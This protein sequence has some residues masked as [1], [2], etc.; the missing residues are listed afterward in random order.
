MNARRRRLVDGPADLGLLSGYTPAEIEL[1][2]QMCLRDHLYFTRFFFKVRESNPFRVGLHHPV[3][4]SAIDRVLRGEITRLIVNI[5][6]GYTKT[7]EVVIALG[8]RAYAINPRA[9]ILHTSAGDQ[10]VQ[11]NSTDIRDIV[12]TVEFQTLFPGVT[13]RQ[14]SKSKGLWRTNAGGQFR[15]APAAGMITGFRAGTMDDPRPE[16][17]FPNFTGLFLIDDPIKPED[18]D[19]E[20]KRVQINERID[21]TFA[22]RLA[23]E[24]VP[25]IVVMQ[26]IHDEDMSGYLLKGRFRGT[27]WHHLFLPVEVPERDE[28][29]NLPYPK[30]FQ[31]GIQIDHDLPPGPLWADKHNATQIEELKRSPSVYAAQYAQVPRSFETSIFKPD[32][33]RAYEL[34]PTMSTVF[35]LVDPSK[36]KRKSQAQRARL[37]DRT[38]I[39]VLMM[40]VNRNLYLVDGYCHRMQLT[41]RWKHLA[42]LYRRY[43]AMPGVQMI[44]FGYEQYGLQ[45]DIEHFNTQMEEHGPR[46]HIEELNYPR[47][48]GHAKE[49]RIERL[50][51]PMVGNRL[52]FPS[53]IYD[54][55]DRRDKFWEGTETGIDLWDA[56]GNTALQERAIK[57]NQ[58]WR[59]A[60]PIKRVDERGQ[61]YDLTKTIMEE[62][63]LFPDAPYDDASDCLSRIVDMQP[64][65]P[66]PSFVNGE[67]SLESDEFFDK[68]ED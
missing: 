37:S 38:A 48:G 15:A 51:A 54:P 49:T 29:G 47:D 65:P 62:L 60:R 67:D 57:N 46:F 2:R 25:I 50:E 43:K 23:T 45:S 28:N 8:A 39:V 22:S 16:S 5:P 3:I 27:R 4:A 18:K 20:T 13:F 34:K 12:N 36:G 68:Y 32:M 21:N 33:F 63:E 6:P 55:N 9:R 41:E 17:P 44:R 7:E 1:T 52:W 40:D 42:A 53:R 24:D 31:Y 11:K 59:V 10:L 64:Q 58:A 19:S 14:D 66:D 26:R 30:Q 35:I 61:I 56:T